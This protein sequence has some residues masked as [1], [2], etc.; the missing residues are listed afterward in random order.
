[1]DC[2]SQVYRF[3][4]WMTT[5]P[6]K[7]ALDMNRIM[8]VTVLVPE[9]ACPRSQARLVARKATMTLAIDKLD[10]HKKSQSRTLRPKSL[11]GPCAWTLSVAGLYHIR[12]SLG[13]GKYALSRVETKLE[14]D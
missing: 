1:M 7:P 9:A 2:T 13:D 11:R 3:G 14:I 12:L 6:S 10:W 4:H 5:S 8:G